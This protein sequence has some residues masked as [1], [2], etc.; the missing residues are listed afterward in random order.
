MQL[1]PKV[2]P[3]TRNVADYTRHKK[4]LEPPLLPQLPFNKETVGGFRY[5]L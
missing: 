1:P 5:A 3:A 4:T 2:S